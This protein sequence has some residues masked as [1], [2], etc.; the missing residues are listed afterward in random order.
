MMGPSPAGGNPAA[1]HPASKVLTISPDLTVGGS[2]PG[3]VGGGQGNLV[4]ETVVWPLGTATVAPT[5]QAEYL[6]GIIVESGTT[7]GAFLWKFD[8]IHTAVFPSPASNTT[9]VAAGASRRLFY[10]I[11]DGPVG[12][13][14]ALTSAL[15]ALGGLQ[16]V[17]FI[18]S[19]KQNPT[20]H[21]WKDLCGVAVSAAVAQAASPGTAETFTIPGVNARPTGFTGIIGY[22]TGLT[23]VFQANF[24]MPAFGQYGV[25]LIPGESLATGGMR[26]YP[27]IWPV[28]FF[29]PAGSFT[30]NF[31]TLV[32]TGAATVSFLGVLWYQPP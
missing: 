28:S 11:N 3:S 2:A 27:T 29:D 23:D 17:Y 30:I 4:Y 15:N 7:P 12:S 31:N 32:L 13:G 10:A 5:N 8:G 24:L 25:Q 20:G 6:V 26:D 1:I 18:F 21:K 19:N 9:N 14:Y 22:P 16:N